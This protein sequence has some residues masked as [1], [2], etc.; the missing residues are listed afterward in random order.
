MPVTLELIRTRVHPED[1]SLIEKMKAI[2]RA[3]GGD[4]AFEWQ[5]RLTMP[6][7]SLK[8]MHAVAHATRGQN[9]QLEYIA[10]VQDVT[11]RRLSEEARDKARMELAHVARAM[12]LGTMA[13]SIAHEISQPLSGIVTNASTCLRMLAAERQDS[14]LNDES[15]FPALVAHLRRDVLGKAEVVQHDDRD[16]GREAFE[17]TVRRISFF[18]N[19][20]I[21]LV[22]EICKVRA[23]FGLWRDLCRDEYAI[24]DVALG[25]RLLELAREQG[26]GK[27][28]PF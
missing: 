5:F 22:P 10:A 3:G 15:G 23:Y 1:V 12:S 14:E 18:I 16:V 27:E 19:S 21:E 17:R 9:D 7:R 6:D 24:D 2:Q 25:A 26:L 13:A 20:G 4:T 8:Y 11:V 28:L